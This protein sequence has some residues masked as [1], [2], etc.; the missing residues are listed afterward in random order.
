MITTLGLIRNK[1]IGDDYYEIKSYYGN[2]FQ[3]WILVF[4]KDAYKRELETLTNKLA[5][6][7][8]S[9]ERRIKQICKRKYQDRDEARKAHYDLE[10]KYGFFNF[11]YNVRKKQIKKETFFELS[12]TYK[13]NEFK[14]IEKENSL[15][16]FILA[17]NVTDYK[18]L[19]TTEVLYAYKGQ[20]RV[21]SK[22][23]LTKDPTFNISDVYLKKPERIKALLCIMSLSLLLYSF[24]QHFLRDAIEKSDVYIT[25][26][27]KKKIKNPTTKQILKKLTGVDLV[28]M[29]ING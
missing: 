1:K 18:E 2:I 13:R 15:G 6:E 4:S 11:E 7:E 5:K 27:N 20:S 16:R 3:R 29:T 12:V 25:N 21:E 9:I 10:S 28:Q 26:L 19:P 17:T 24:I 22:F 23:K 8:L 14:I